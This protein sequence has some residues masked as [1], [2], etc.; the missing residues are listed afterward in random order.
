[1][2][3]R[4]RLENIF[5]VSVCDWLCNLKLEHILW[6]T[7]TSFLYYWGNN[8]L[9]CTW[10]RKVDHSFFINKIFLKITFLSHFY[11]TKLLVS[12]F[13]FFFKKKYRSNYALMN[14]WV[15]NE[16]SIFRFIWNCACLLNLTTCLFANSLQKDLLKD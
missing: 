15:S 12:L 8:I 6:M 9:T 4:F 16:I 2:D 5:N 13:H 7:R 3:S 10:W 1:M 11:I 14:F